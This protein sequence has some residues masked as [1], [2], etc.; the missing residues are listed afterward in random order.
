MNTIGF[1]NFRRFT[2]FPEMELG[3]MTILVGGNNSGKSTLV[4]A[5]LLCVDNLRLMTESANGDVLKI[6]M[7]QFHFD[8]NECH[9]VKIKTF[10]RAIHN[11][12]VSVKEITELKPKLVYPSTIVFKF[13]LQNFKFE[14][15]IQGDKD[16]DSVTGDVYKVTIEDQKNM[17]KYVMN[18]RNQN[19]DYIVLGKTSEEFTLV[20]KL[21]Q[22]CFSV[23]KELKRLSIE[24][25]DISAISQQGEK[26]ESL[27]QRLEDLTGINFTDCKTEKDFQDSFI[28]YYEKN[29]S[30]SIVRQ[31]I[32]LPVENYINVA[33]E[34]L[35][36]HVIGNFIGF[37]TNPGV[38]FPKDINDADEYMALSSKWGMIEDAREFMH[39]EVDKIR[40]SQNDLS[41]LIKLIRVEY[42]SAHAANQNTIYNTADKN[43]YIAQTVHEFYKQRIVAGD[44]EYEFIKKWMERFDIGASFSIDCIGGEAYRVKIK[45]T[46]LSEVN[47]ADK[48][49]GAIQ[50]MLLLIRLATIMRK[51]QTLQLP[52]DCADWQKPII[53][54]EEPEQNLHPKMQSL[55]AD[56]FCE[57]VDRGNCKFVI[58]THSEY[59][60]RKTQV[61][62]KNDGKYGT[63]IQLGYVDT[64]IFTVYYFDGNNTKIPYYKM[65]YRDDGCFENDF[66]EGF[67]DE[68]EKLAFEII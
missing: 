6:N 12:P 31:E 67:F 23:L 66:G 33:N 52:L 48:G 54:I 38:A 53:V 18:Y 35:F 60:I 63:P 41:N 26:V 43:D 58:E 50:M 68:A 46:D 34:N 8:A 24:D 59:L 7:P 17:V 2:N 32:S 36:V 25:D 44:R 49:M 30:E 16:E 14:I 37:A 39:Q 1:E 61:I 27:K 13:T 42:I 22:E 65:Q 57:M 40:K 28:K 62:V 5:L 29:W 11:K 55:L 19:M 45:D 15:F 9:D 10:S 51:Y 56:L 3:D 64:N 47:L 4:K 21:Y 20:K